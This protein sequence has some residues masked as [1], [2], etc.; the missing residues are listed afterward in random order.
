M[1]PPAVTLVHFQIETPVVKF[2]T[3]LTFK[4]GLHSEAK[5]AQ[6]LI[7]DYIIHHKKANGRTTPK[8]FKWKG[9]R[10]HSGTTHHAVKKH[11]FK[12]ITTRVYYPGLH[13]LELLINGEVQGGGTFELQM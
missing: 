10:L 1:P 11:P 9:L 6:D 12:T 3:P 2:G 8:V 4:I 13:R 5:E 7:I